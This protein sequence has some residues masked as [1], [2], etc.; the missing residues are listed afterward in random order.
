MISV[1]A[2]AWAHTIPFGKN[3]IQYED[4][5]WSTHSRSSRSTSPP[6]TPGLGSVQ[7]AQFLLSDLPGDHI[8]FAGISA[9]QINGVSNLA[10]SFS[11]GELSV[12]ALPRVR[13]PART[14]TRQS[15]RSNP[16]PDTSP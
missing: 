6:R 12:L 13:V 14:R 15:D 10:D 9:A 7:G 4:F 3:T 16:G 1:A 11:R 8:L 2:N 5:N